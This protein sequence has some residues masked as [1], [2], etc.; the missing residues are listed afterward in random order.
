MER[1]LRNRL[2]LLATIILAVPIAG[3]IASSCALM[4]PP[5]KTL[6]YTLTVDTGLGA[7]RGYDS[8]S[9]WLTRYLGPYS[10]AHRYADAPSLSQAADMK[11]SLSSNP[12]GEGTEILYRLR[13]TALDGRTE[14]DFHVVD[15]IR[16][17][18]VMSFFLEPHEPY[19]EKTRM[20][21]T[22]ADYEAFIA[23]MGL[24]VA[25]YEKYLGKKS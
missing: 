16:S 14:F 3:A 24:L 15:D 11:V 23:K 8:A 9:S 5:A 4:P 19:I 21:V 18:L 7:E 10:K 13:I 22:Q 20:I 17:T 25:D 6:D 1:S 12:Q 2:S